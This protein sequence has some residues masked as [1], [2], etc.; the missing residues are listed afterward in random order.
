MPNRVAKVAV[1]AA[2]YSIDRPYD[3]L[4]PEEFSDAICVGTRVELPF[5]KS[6]FDEGQLGLFSCGYRKTQP[7][8]S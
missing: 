7:N 1:S 3:Y 8:L 6:D 2:T 5:G 4:I